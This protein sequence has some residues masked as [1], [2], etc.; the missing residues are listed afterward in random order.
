MKQIKDLY[1]GEDHTHFIDTL[2]ITGSW[3]TSANKVEVDWR[4]Y[5]W[6]G[7]KFLSKQYQSLTTEQINRHVERI[8]NSHVK[9]LDKLYETV[10]ADYNPIENY[11]M[12]ETGGDTAHTSAS[13]DNTDYVTTYESATLKKSGNNESSSSADSST[14]HSLTRSGNI[15]VTTTQQMIEQ[16]RQVALYDFYGHIANM[17]NNEIA[18]SFYP[19]E[20]SYI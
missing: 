11:N 17:I 7:E 14:T 20:V 18:C 1:S 15:G 10:T 6:Y 8:I 3:A 16:E 13:G 5:Q 2:H 12:T 4:L 9:E 19:E